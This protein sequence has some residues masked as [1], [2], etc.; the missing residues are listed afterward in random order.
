MK[1]A[2]HSDHIWDM[3]KRRSQTQR[4]ISRFRRSA[5]RR[6]QSALSGQGRNRR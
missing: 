3:L 5:L 2:I 4:T 1:T 6:L